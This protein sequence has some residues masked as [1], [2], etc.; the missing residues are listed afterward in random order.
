MQSG[1]TGK[2]N[3]HN[4]FDNQYLSFLGDKSFVVCLSHDV[5]N[6]RKRHQYFSK[7]KQ[8]PFGQVKSLFSRKEPYWN[9]DLIMDIESGYN[10]KSTFFFYM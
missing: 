7:F 10:V 2:L 5:D 6:V 4:F 1:N 8:D 9:F 3:N